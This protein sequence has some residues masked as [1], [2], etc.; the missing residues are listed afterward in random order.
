MKILKKLTKKTRY[1]STF[2]RETKKMFGSNDKI[3]IV[4]QEKKLEI[5]SD[6][7]NT[8]NDLQLHWLGFF[9]KL[10]F[11]FPTFQTFKGESSK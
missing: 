7:E 11:Q 2:P 6:Y 1:V 10:K 8:I 9:Q 3:I 5:L 4:L